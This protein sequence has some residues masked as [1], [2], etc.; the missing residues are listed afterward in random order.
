MND[1]SGEAPMKRS[2]RHLCL[3]LA[4][5]LAAASLPIAAEQSISLRAEATPELR[6]A[7]NERLEA[8]WK[9]DAD[10]WARL[11]ADEFTL[12]VPE[13][14]LM[15]KSERIA[16]LKVEPAEPRHEVKKETT[17]MY[18]DTAVHRFVDGTE[19]VLEVWHRENGIWRVVAAQVNLVSR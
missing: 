6:Q 11:T 1:L 2:I 14:T 9:K 16:A 4:L 13:G 18:G 12:V 15:N 10:A 17:H 3:V 5:T 8:V 19:W 7:I